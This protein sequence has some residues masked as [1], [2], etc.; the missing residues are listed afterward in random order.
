MYLNIPLQEYQYMCF[1]KMTV[2][3]DMIDH[4]NLQDKMTNDRRMYCEKKQCM[5]KKFGKSANIKLKTVLTSEEYKPN[6]FR[7]WL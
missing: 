1:N 6:C 2:P 4:Y 5:D 3:K 7:Y